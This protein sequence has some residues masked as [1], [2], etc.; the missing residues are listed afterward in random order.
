MNWVDQKFF[1]VQNII[2][3]Q[4]IPKKILD[5]GCRNQILKKFIPDHFLYTGVDI[6]Q[7]DN[8][9]NILMDLNQKILFDD[10]SYDYVFL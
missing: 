2:K 10:N 7:N 1:Y 3:N 5:L 6:I 9:D 8:S 4:S